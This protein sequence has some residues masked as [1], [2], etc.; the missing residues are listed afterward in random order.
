MTG[1][2]DQLLQRAS[3]GNKSAINQL[4][5]RHRDRLRRMVAARMDVGMRSRI[6]PSDVIQD[7]LAEAE[8]Q[9]RRYLR[10][11]P[12]AFYPWLRQIAWNRLVDLYRQHVLA[13][14]RSVYREASQLLSADSI[15]IVAEKLVSRE[16]GPS[17]FVLRQEMNER[18]RDAL[19]QVPE[20]DREIII[21]RHIEQ[22]S[23]AEVAEVLQLPEGTIKSRHFRA[24]QRVRTSLDSSQ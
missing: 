2:T 8:Q 13:D 6:D 5:A 3:L 18:L 4:L 20:T 24:L 1:D 9:L 21:L 14:K 12:V 10:E 15:R 22:L 19:Q 16:P 23:V 11:R 7:T 17:E